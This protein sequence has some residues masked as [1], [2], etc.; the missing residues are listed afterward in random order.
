MIELL[1]NKKPIQIP[2]SWNDI[3][4]A[5]YCDIV[6]AGELSLIDRLKVY[7]GLQADVINKLT[8]ETLSRLSEIV[9]F[10]DRP[11]DVAVLAT[12]YKGKENIETAAYWKL[13]K[14]K[15]IIKE[16][17]NPLFAGVD[18]VKLYTGDD[19]ADKPILSVYDQACFFLP[20]LKPLQT[21][22]QG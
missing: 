12:P 13:E 19:I 1:L 8:L 16:R 11:E 9:G 10:M 15:L 22:S 17:G 21:G 20:N 3:T 4:Y 14:A 7:T 5:K 6:K 18:V 2:S